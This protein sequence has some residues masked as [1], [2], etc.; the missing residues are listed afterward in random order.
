MWP[1]FE[2]HIKV[3]DSR[4]QLLLSLSVF[5]LPVYHPNFWGL[6][7]DYVIMCNKLGII[8]NPT[9]IGLQEKES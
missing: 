7:I 6:W 4:I 8:N 1:M 9:M 3:R 2:F 5:T